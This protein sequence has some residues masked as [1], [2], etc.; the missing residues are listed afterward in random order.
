MGTLNVAITVWVAALGLHPQQSVTEDE[1]D[2]IEVNH[3]YDEH[4]K[5]VFDQ[6]IF[7]DWSA[8]SSRYQVR[9]WRL[10]K[11]DSQLPKRNWKRREFVSVWHDGDTLR[12][13]RAAAVRQTWTQYDP[14]LMDRE[15]LP[16]E[17]RREL[18]KPFPF[19]CRDR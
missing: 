4:G 16:K 15:H 17:R 9:A 14:E 5:L 19:P 7:Y 18:G 1:V 11:T 2:L 13:V 8:E 12:Q 3:F 6:I 10:L